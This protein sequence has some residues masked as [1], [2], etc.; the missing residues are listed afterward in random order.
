[1]NVPVIVD[2][3]DQIP[4]LSNLW[5]Y[6]QEMGA[7]LAIF[8][9]GKGLRGPQ[10]SGIIVGRADLIAACRANS[11]PYPSVGRPAKVGKEEMVGLLAALELALRQDERD[12]AAV[13]SKMV[14]GW[15]AGLQDVPGITLERV[16]RTHSG[17]PIPRAIV[18]LHNG[19]RDAAIKA[20]W[21]RNPRIA[22]LPEGDDALAPNPH[23]LTPGEDKLVLQALREVLSAHV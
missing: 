19:E 13:W 23:H 14:D 3:A 9:G 10:A 6:T 8:S 20:L 12:E 2:A 17:Q 18:H 4:P 22:V 7:D 15:I 1:K 5:R 21:E 16:E 11:G